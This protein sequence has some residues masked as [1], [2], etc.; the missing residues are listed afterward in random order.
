M[1]MADFDDLHSIANAYAGLFS[2]GV[3]YAPSTAGPNIGCRLAR[4]A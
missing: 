3:N 2:L 1:I 4:S